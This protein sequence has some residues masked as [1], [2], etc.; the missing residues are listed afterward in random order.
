METTSSTE[1]L[2]FF[3]LQFSCLDTLAWWRRN[4]NNNNRR[5]KNSDLLSA[6][7]T[8]I[9]S[10]DDEAKTYKIVKICIQRVNKLV[11]FVSIYELELKGTEKTVISLTGC[12]LSMFHSFVKICEKKR[13]KK[14]K[15][16]N[17]QINE[18]KW[19]YWYFAI[20]GRFFSHLSL[21]K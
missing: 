10:A 20:N 9:C 1:F 14:I 19:Y 17:K 2:S 3:I 8:N 13:R 6:F 21:F 18:T 4:K 12:F 11:I 16:K 7:K 5:K 15:C